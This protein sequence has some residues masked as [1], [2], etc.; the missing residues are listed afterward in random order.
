[1]GRI[2][3]AGCGLG[4]FVIALKTLGY[5]AEGVDYGERTI[6]FLNERFPD[7]PFRIGD[8]TNL[9]VPDGYY[10]G[11]ISLGVMEHLQE[12]PEI[13]LKEAHRILANDGIALISVP[14]I[15]GLCR[16]K[17]GLGMFNGRVPDNL[18]F[19]QF[20]YSASEF[21]RCLM[22]AG[23]VPMAHYQYG[24]YKGVKD[25]LS[26]FSK[27]FSMPQ[28]GWRLN[29]VFDEVQVGRKSYGTHDDVCMQKS[30][31]TVSAG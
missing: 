6:R 2:L 19:Y 28:I 12:G 5:Q 31:L 15:N 1:M 24:G 14:Y 7:Y 4:Q 27:L 8:V 29:K 30:D 11:Y 16:L 10:G 9:D 22:N 25:E 20:A 21:D 18:E 26:F 17:M 3:E 23:F 13:F